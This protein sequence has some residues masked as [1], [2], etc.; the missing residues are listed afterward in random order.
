MHAAFCKRYMPRGI[1]LFMRIVRRG[2]FFDMI[3]TLCFNQVCCGVFADIGI[4][5]TPVFKKNIFV[6]NSLMFLADL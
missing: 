1:S 4:Y 6:L 5:H 3:L 2:H